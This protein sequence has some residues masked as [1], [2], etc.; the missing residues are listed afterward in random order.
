MADPATTHQDHR[1][2][3][4]TPVTN[5][6]GSATTPERP[7]VDV[8]DMI[9]VHTALLREFRL[10]PAAV[11]RVGAGNRRQ[12]AGIDRHLG[13]ICEVLH[14]HHTGEE[15]LLWPPLRT[16]IAENAIPL[17][18]TAESEH[19]AVEGALARV[20]AARQAWV[21][22][23]SAGMSGHLLEALENLHTRLSEHLDAEERNILPLA[24]GHL[25]HGEWASIGQAGAAAIPGPARPLV[26]GMFA[27]EGDPHVVA[28]MLHSAP[29]LARLLLPWLA[30]R[31][32]G[33][34]ALQIYGT[35]HP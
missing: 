20:V 31:V 25:T 9:V 16:R 29:A 10:A 34:R 3:Q 22:Q 24:A 23:P 12:A 11:R 18:E 6:S 30:P 35:R 1:V 8:R 17:L 27:Y 15:E 2:S 26:F 14:H 33:R 5:T 28:H 13:L 21:D 19:S 32:Y 7:L 4:P